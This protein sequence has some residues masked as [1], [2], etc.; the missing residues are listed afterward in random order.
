VMDASG[1][2]DA[3]VLVAGAAAFGRATYNNMTGAMSEADPLATLGVSAVVLHLARATA[4]HEPLLKQAAQLGIDLRVLAA[5][6]GKEDRFRSKIFPSRHADS[7]CSDLIGAISE[8][9][10]R[11]WQLAAAQPA[12]THLLVLEDDVSLPKNFSSYFARGLRALPPT[13]DMAL[14]GTTST[15]SVRKVPGT[16]HLLRPDENEPTGQAILG[17]YAYVVSRDGA[18]RLLAQYDATQRSS[19]SRFT[20]SMSPRWASSLGGHGRR[21]YQC[22]AL[23]LP[24]PLTSAWPPLF[25]SAVCCLLSAVC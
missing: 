16:A 9:H 22:R 17:F 7:T 20:P 15:E 10:R 14:V 3:A 25:W 13:Y 19:G 4:R 18:T 5:S 24:R 1:V 8:S 23:D 6:D 12:G 21:V 2:L 11:A